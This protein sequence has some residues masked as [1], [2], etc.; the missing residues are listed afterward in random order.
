ME[1]LVINGG[2]PLHGSVP[3]SGA[4]NAVLPIL[5]ATVLHGGK[6]VLCNC[7]DIADVR[8]AVEILQTLGAQVT[9]VGDVLSVDTRDLCGYMIPGRLMLQMRASVLFLG[10]LLARHG[11]AVLTLPGGCPLG[12]RPIDLHLQTMSQ[13]GAAVTLVEEQIRCHGPVLHG[14]TVCFPFPSVGATENAIMAAVACHGSVTIHN[15]AKEPEICDLAAFLQAMGAEIKG[16]GTHTLYITGGMPLHDA[17]YTIM[18]DRIETATYLCA[19][20]ACGGE[21]TLQGAHSD[22]LIPVIQ[23]LR[24]AGCTIEEQDG[25]TIRSDAVLTSVEEIETAPYPG[26]PTDAQAPVM[27]ALLRARGKTRFSETVFEQRFAHVPQLRRFGADI[28]LSGAAAVVSGV[29]TLVPA[30]TEACDLRA[31]AALVIAALQTQGESRIFGL[32]HLDRGY[33]NPERKLSSLGASIR[34]AQ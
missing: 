18:P 7:P 20:A 8:T 23:T 28:R 17:D 26:F 12:H 24:Q 29:E 33:D 1:A 2:M 30:R 25:I 16:V 15:A 31:A 22:H 3:I 14:G 5:A 4:K 9:R 13:L 11:R 21:V 10:P 6:Y 27:A 32:K 34:R 19:A